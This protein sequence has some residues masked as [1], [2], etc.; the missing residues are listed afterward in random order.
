[1]SD[2]RYPQINLESKNEL[3]KRISDRY[4]PYSE[5]LK[6]INDCLENLDHYWYDS[7]ASEPEKEKFVRSARGKPLAEL[8]KRINLAVLAPYDRLV[9]DFIFGGLSYRN[10]VQAAANLLGFQKKR[11]L[12]KLDIS[13]FF[14][15]IGDGR[16][17]H[18]FNKK[19]GC[20]VRAS[21]LLSK[22]CCVPK[23]PKGSGEVSKTLARGFATSPRLAV[24]ANLDIFLKIDLT[25]H[26]MLRGHDPRLV[27]F[28]DDIGI[29]ASRV[30]MSKM[31]EVKEKVI[32]ILQNYD[33]NQTLPVNQDKT[34]VIPFQKIP[35]HLGIK[36][37][38]N[39][40]SPGKKTQL[41]MKNVSLLLGEAKSKKERDRLMIKKQAYRQYKRQ[42]S[43][44]NIPK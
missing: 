13:R 9:P 39:K 12:L 4:L 24:W 3:A 33:P 2:L 40:L 37:G 10:H 11:T 32:D 29:S 27:V 7:R 35:E 17:F 15:R 6:L 34:K 22:I 16:I 26:K 31:Q 5:S 41:R 23:G 18:F 19:C 38:R 42:L 8:L 20:S 43:S 25:V 14:E 36:L 28:V 44:V 1:M 30:E 21:R